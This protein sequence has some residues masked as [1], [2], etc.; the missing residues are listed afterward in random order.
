MPLVGIDHSLELI[1][2]EAPYFTS[3]EELDSWMDT[4]SKQLRSVL[5]Y[6]PRP[7]TENPLNQ[8]QLLVRLIES[9]LGDWAQLFTHP[10]FVM[11]TR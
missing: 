7:K 9:I 4:P 2:D 3:L 8:G 1:G 11:I 6:T 10:R 5:P